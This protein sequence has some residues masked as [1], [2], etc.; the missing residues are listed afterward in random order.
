MRIMLAAVCSSRV[1]NYI[2]SLVCTRSFQ[3]FSIF[4]IALYEYIIISV[5][6]YVYC[7]SVRRYVVQPAFAAQF[8]M[9]S[10]NE[11]RN[12]NEIQGWETKATTHGCFVHP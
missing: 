10:S 8:L 4:S 9:G 11:A 5:N 7:I 1:L 2:F 3:D 12:M 6:V